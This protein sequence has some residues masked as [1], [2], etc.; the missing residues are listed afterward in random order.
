M[1]HGS[2][3]YI[4]IEA[5]L[6]L[7]GSRVDWF[8]RYASDFGC[9][10]WLIENKVELF[11]CCEWMFGCTSIAIPLRFNLRFA[12]LSKLTMEKSSLPAAQNPR[13]TP[14]INCPF[15]ALELNDFNKRQTQVWLLSMI[16]SCNSIAIPRWCNAKITALPHNWWGKCLLPEAQDCHYNLAKAHYMLHDRAACLT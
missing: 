1:L 2:C 16:H 7:W 12:T 5:S 9:C 3:N 14:N 15:K 10:E 6:S 13:C 11:G 4:A 8:E